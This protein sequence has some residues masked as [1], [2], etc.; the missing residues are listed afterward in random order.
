MAIHK[1]MTRSDPSWPWWRWIMAGLSTLALTLSIVLSWHSLA[2]GSMVGCGGG[3]GCDQVLNSRWSTIAGII[4][5]SG[6]AAGAYLAML[7]AIFFIG[8]AT[9][10]H[11]RRLAWSAMLVLVGAAAGSAVWFFIVQK[12]IIGA[13]CLYCMTTHMTGVLL[14]TLVIWRRLKPFRDDSTERPSKCMIGPLST[15]GLVMTGLV[16]A[17]TLATCQVFFTGPAVYVEGASTDELPV[18]DHRAVPMVGSPDAPTIVTLLF[19]YQCP[20]CQKMHFMLDEAIR[21]TN[22]QLAFALC[23]APLNTQCN[24]HVPQEATQFENSCELVKVGMAVWVAKR[25]AFSAFEHWM[26]TFESGDRWSPRS[27]EAARAKAVELV[28]QAPF[29]AAWTD[30]WIDQYIQTSVKIFGDTGGTAIPKLVFGS[31]WVIPE[32]YS[33]DD[34]MTILQDGLAVPKP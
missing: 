26:F 22:G 32:P 28:G 12:W 3:S 13:F 5:V 20:H 16:I 7:M 14:A 2:G 24:P 4:P 10:W 29:D 34:L 21:R 6:L 33:V 8:P 15:L 30:P 23:P 11:V 27:L 25:E 17:G 18:M 1:H 31:R 19:D 9:E